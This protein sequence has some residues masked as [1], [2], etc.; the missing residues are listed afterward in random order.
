LVVFVFYLLIKRLLSFVVVV[1]FIAFDF[2]HNSLF[3]L[4]LDPVSHLQ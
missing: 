3:S 1:H 2:A 4:L